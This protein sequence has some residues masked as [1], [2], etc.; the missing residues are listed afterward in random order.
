M[1]L[2]CISLQILL[3][4]TLIILVPRNS[5]LIISYISMLYMIYLRGSI[6]TRPFKRDIRKMSREPSALWWIALRSKKLLWLPTGDMN[7]IML[8]LISRKKD[9][10]FWSGSEMG[11][12]VSKGSW[13]SPIHRSLILISSS[14]LQGNSQMKSW[15]FA[16]RKINAAVCQR[17]PCLTISHRKVSIVHPLLFM[18]WIFGSFN[19]LSQKIV[20][21]RYWPI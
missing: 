8:W 14:I 4:P 17:I 20:M 7:L 12:G 9:G 1:V 18:S 3:I 15:P 13:I 21:K 19:S 6:M 2:I 16:K 11:S 5:S 10:I